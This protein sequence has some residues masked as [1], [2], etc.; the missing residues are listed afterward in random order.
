[1]QYLAVIEQGVLLQT[2]RHA[3]E[4]L[5]KQLIELGDQ[6][7][8]L[9][10]ELQTAESALTSVKDK[11]AAL[12]EES[13]DLKRNGCELQQELDSTKKILAGA[14]EAEHK[15]AQVSNPTWMHVKAL[16]RVLDF[17]MYC[18]T[19]TLFHNTLLDSLCV[20]LSKVPKSEPNSMSWLFC[21]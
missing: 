17:H 3:T 13:K 21:D 6:K 10:Q 8:V 16:H 9:D 7:S 5:Q 19:I 12:E 4:T 15:A 20:G 1:M 2:H 18:C 11:A 14:E